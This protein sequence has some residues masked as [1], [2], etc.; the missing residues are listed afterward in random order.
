VDVKSSTAGVEDVH[1]G[2]PGDTAREDIE[3]SGILLCVLCTGVRLQR[4]QRGLNTVVRISSNHGSV[5]AADRLN[6]YGYAIAHFAAPPTPDGGVAGQ[7]CWDAQVT[8]PNG[9]TLP[10]EY[11][12]ADETGNRFV[13]HDTSAL[14]ELTWSASTTDARG[15]QKP[16]PTDRAA[17]AWYGTSPFTFDVNLTDAAHRSACTYWTGTGWGGPSGS[18]CWTPP[19]R[20]FST[21][22]TCRTSA[23]GSTCPGSCPATCSSE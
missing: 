5:S 13:Y 6:P 8:V 21:P 17:S 16:V 4:V 14:Q 9:W 23:T 10:G 22:K 1:A 15:L 2:S 11:T 3:G 20:P 12:L 7:G 18:R 19:P